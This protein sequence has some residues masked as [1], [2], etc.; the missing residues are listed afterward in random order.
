[1]RFA[2]TECAAIDWSGARPARRTQARPGL[3]IRRSCD[4]LCNPRTLWNQPLRGLCSK[5]SSL[6]PVLS[7]Q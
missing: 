2:V 3:P 7:G 4:V 1:M 6:V 5:L